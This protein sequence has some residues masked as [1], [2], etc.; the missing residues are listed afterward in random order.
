MTD[1]TKFTFETLRLKQL[2]RQSEKAIVN[3]FREVQSQESREHAEWVL[4]KIEGEA[5]LNTEEA[6]LQRN[7]DSLG[8]ICFGSK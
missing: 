4:E 2:L 1:E 6:R 5:Q 3:C 7:Q 8:E